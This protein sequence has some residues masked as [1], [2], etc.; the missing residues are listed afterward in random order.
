MLFTSLA[1]L[2]NFSK[3][4]KQDSR[5]YSTSAYAR[6]WLFIVVFFISNGKSPQLLIVSSKIRQISTLFWI[7]LISENAKNRVCHHPVMM[8]IRANKHVHNIFEFAFLNSWSVCSLSFSFAVL[9]GI[10]CSHGS[11]LCYIY[12]LKA[13]IYRIMLWKCQKIW[14]ILHRF[15]WHCDSKVFWC[16]FLRT[17][18]TN[19]RTVRLTFTIKSRWNRFNCAVVQSVNKFHSCVKNQVK[20]KQELSRWQWNWS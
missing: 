11:G 6:V 15:E 17:D 18:I 8:S 1:Q 2:N 19:R 9:F 14:I 5:V 3:R 10:F 12:K 4:G 16:E 13:L 20:S 7:K